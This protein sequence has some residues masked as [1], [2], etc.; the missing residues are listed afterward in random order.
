MRFQAVYDLKSF[1]LAG[2][3][4][5]INEHTVERQRLQVPFSQFADRNVFDELCV[6]VGLGIRIVKAV[7]VFDE[8][9]RGATVTLR[10]QKTAGIC[11]MGWNTPKT[12]RVLP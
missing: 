7:N 8:G 9:V 10:E 12:R 11:A 3:S 2:I 6:A 5:E 4:E 1:H